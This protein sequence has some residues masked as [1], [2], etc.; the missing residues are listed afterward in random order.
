LSDYRY[1]EKRRPGEGLRIGCT[2]YLPRGIK[3]SNLAKWDLMDVWL[4]TLAPSRRLMTWAKN[5]RLPDDKRWQTFLRRYRHEMTQTTPRQTIRTLAKL[6]KTT[7]ILVGCFC[8]A[9]QC[10]RFELERLIRRAAV[11]RF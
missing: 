10:H 2:R 7:P 1:G 9:N 6:A 5:T 4:P 8:Q 3:R 11:G